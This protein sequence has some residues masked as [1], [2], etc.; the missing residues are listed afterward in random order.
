[1]STVFLP[2]SSFNYILTGYEPGF[3]GC[4]LHRLFARYI[5]IFSKDEEEH[6]RHVAQVLER[7][8]MYAKLSKCVSLYGMKYRCSIAT[9]VSTSTNK[10]R[11]PRV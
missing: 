6:K 5:L 9:T 4:Y 2:P 10:A 11:P 7:Y 3:A 1:M 8:Y